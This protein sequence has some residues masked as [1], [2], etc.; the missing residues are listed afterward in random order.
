MSRTRRVGLVS[1]ELPPYLAHK[2]RV[3]ALVRDA[4]TPDGLTDGIRLARGV[5]ASEF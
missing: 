5:P 1:S 2:S 4:L 3:V